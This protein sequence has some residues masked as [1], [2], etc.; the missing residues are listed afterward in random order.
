MPIELPVQLYL[1]QL[2]LLGGINLSF[3]TKLKES[4]IDKILLDQMDYRYAIIPAW[5]PEKHWDVAT[6]VDPSKILA[7]VHGPHQT[8]VIA[9]PNLSMQ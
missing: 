6:R 1:V 3:V 9:R 5:N 2:F 4:E 7:W 8:L